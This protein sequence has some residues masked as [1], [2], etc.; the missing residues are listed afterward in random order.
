MSFTGVCKTGSECNEIFKNFYM[1][2]RMCENNS[3]PK[4]LECPVR[5][6]QI[7]QEGEDFQCHLD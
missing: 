2:N 3:L 1:N 7:F 6:K 5:G 4:I